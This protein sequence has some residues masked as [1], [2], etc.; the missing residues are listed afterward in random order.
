L[1]AEIN[2][3]LC[4]K[5]PM[6]LNALYGQPPLGLCHPSVGAEQF[7]PLMPGSR[8]LE[9]LSEKIDSM[10]MLAPPGTMERRYVMAKTIQAL[11]ENAPFTVLA[12]KDKGGSRIAKELKEFGC[13]IEEDA[14]SHHRICTLRRPENPVGLEAAIAEGAPR[15][16]EELGMHTQPGVFSW[17]RFDLGSQLLL[18][19]MPPMVGKGADLGCGIGF[20]SREILKSPKVRELHLL[21]I[22]GRSILAVKKN[23]LDPRAKFYWADLRTSNLIPS[24]LDFV[25]TNPPFHD[26]GVE[27]QSLGRDFLRQAA[28]LLRSGGICWIVA[29]R[30]L[31]Y[32]SILKEVF[33]QVN[34][35][36]EAN[37][38]KIFEAIR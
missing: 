9:D 19:K 7:S 30:H 14:R 15:Y 24:G 36:A 21:E 2:R 13:E 6:P 29:N 5:P 3:L 37:G 27:D 38:F 33:S 18:E 11:A 26:G 35:K 22:D 32:E 25:V 16:S 31:P 12:P 1:E 4:Y 8:S 34:Q 17:N 10:T 20:L 23:I 28:Y